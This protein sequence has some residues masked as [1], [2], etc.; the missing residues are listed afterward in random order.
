MKVLHITGMHSTKYG[1]LEKFNIELLR[2]GVELILLYNSEI[3]CGE[4]KRELE[5]LGAKVYVL[6]EG[7]LAQLR[8]VVHIIRATRP[9]LIHF[10]FG[11]LKYILSPLLRVLFPRL[12]QI[13]TQ[14]CEL[15]DV[16]RVNNMIIQLFFKCQ[17]H[18]ISVSKLVME[19]LIRR[20]GCANKSE[21]LY[22]G[23]KKKPV[24]NRAL[25]QDL[26]ISAESIIFTTLGWDIYIK[27]YDTLISAIDIL[28]QRTTQPFIVLVIGLP[29]V[30]QAK[31][32]PMIERKG[33][34]DQ[35]KSIGVRNDVDDFLAISDIYL[36]PSRTEALPLSIMEALCHK[37]PTIATNVGGIAEICVDKYNGILIEK[38][39]PQ[40][41][42]NAMEELLDPL[43]RKK[44]SAHAEDM[45]THFTLDKQVSELITVYKKMVHIK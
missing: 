8:Q 29:E 22:L 32:N 39:D 15:W 10:H 43:I 44:Y 37:L 9:D 3:S 40:L 17:D 7:R 38:D 35:I 45:S 23:V 27:G 13:T 34:A 41:L 33:L 28:R 1:G 31:I 42:A 14:H 11:G 36:Q 4:Y 2:Q 24:K 6:R 5:K 25:K 30:E 18:I 20:Y 16:D 21:V 26:N 12:P 19:D